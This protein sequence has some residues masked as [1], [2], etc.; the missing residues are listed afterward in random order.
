MP[1]PADD[2]LIA[3]TKDVIGLLKGAFHTP[4]GFRPAHAKGVLLSGKFVPSAT[5]TSLSSAPHFTAASTPVLAR[6]S[7][8]TGIP[9]IPDND[10]NAKPNGLA[11]RFQLPNDPATGHRKHTDIIGHSTPHFPVNTGVLF[12]DLLKA[13]GAGGDAPGKFL[14][15]HPSALRFVTAPKPFTKSYA[16]QEYYALH[17]FGLQKD[18][19]TTW[20][21]YTVTPSGGI[22]TISEDEATKLGPN[23]LHD[24][25][26]KR[27]TSGT[28]VELKIVGTLA[29]EGDN[30]ND[31]TEEWEGE[32]ETVELGTVTL[33]G[34]VT[35]DATVQKNSIFDPVPRVEG[36]TEADNDAIMEF[37][38]ALYLISGRE[39]R[40]A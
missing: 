31:I 14:G 13:L 15:A 18:G 2:V 37:R 24:E 11:I 8:S 21:K 32:H 3:Q 9:V 7:N 38:A 28:P 40:A 17:T 1:L 22:E 33:S 29:K 35:D 6:F 30:T 23:Y 34:T 26:L 25:I 5:A 19:K 4:P 20:L 27:V 36:V 16:T 10:G 12:G 39:R